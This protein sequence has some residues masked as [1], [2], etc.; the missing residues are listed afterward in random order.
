MRQIG[1]G[2]GSELHGLGACSLGSPMFTH[3]TR[4]YDD[5][6]LH[7]QLSNDESSGPDSLGKR[8][9]TLVGLTPVVVTVRK[10]L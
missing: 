7:R 2:K 6:I 10:L 8:T 3:P 9:R 4:V 1:S 5:N